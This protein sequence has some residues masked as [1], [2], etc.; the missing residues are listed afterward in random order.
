MADTY[1]LNPNQPMMAGGAA[2]KSEQTRN[3]ALIAA[4]AIILA[5]LIYWWGSS[6]SQVPSAVDQQAQL[7]AQVAAML[8]SAPP[9]ATPQ[10]VNM[11]ASQL[12]SAPAASA[13]TTA[14]V[15]ANVAAML[16]S[17]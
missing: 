7:R 2:G 6:V 9:K 12:R 4:G 14:A 11:V 17:Q 1:S 3:M 8:N 16:Q 13:T 15:R 10:E 5:G